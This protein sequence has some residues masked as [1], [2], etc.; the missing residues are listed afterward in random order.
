MFKILRAAAD[1]AA[2]FI[3]TTADEVADTAETVI[4][5]LIAGLG[6]LS[7]L[8]SMITALLSLCGVSTGSVA[9]VLAFVTSLQAFLTEWEDKIVSLIVSGYSVYEDT[10][11]F[12]KGL[13]GLFS[14]ND[15]DDTAETA[16][17][18]LAKLYAGRSRGYAVSRAAAKAYAA[19]MAAYVAGVKLWL[20]D[21]PTASF[22]EQ[23][24][25][26][27]AFAAKAKRAQAV[28]LSAATARAIA[29]V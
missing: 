25:A 2:G 12:L 14:S 1:K 22:T 24:A 8:G 16:T 28:R 15:D 17:A 5:D 4:D 13:W 29:A 11:S 20:A 7:P 26:V 10:V 27:N 9:T 23:R 3:K 19:D 6:S 18:S 21:H